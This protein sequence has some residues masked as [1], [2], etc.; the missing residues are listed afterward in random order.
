MEFV[1]QRDFKTKAD[2]IGLGE[3][4]NK[5]NDYG[6]L[7]HALEDVYKQMNLP[8]KTD[9]VLMTEPN[10]HSKEQRA[11]LTEI[12]FEGMDVPSFFFCKSAVLAW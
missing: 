3:T 10:V 1:K 12:F 5:D 2:S 8:N 6:A 9:P 11:A 4:D 7:K